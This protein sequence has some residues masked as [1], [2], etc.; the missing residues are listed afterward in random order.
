[1]KPYGY[2]REPLYFVCPP[3]NFFNE[4]YV[5]HEVRG[6]ETVALSPSINLTVERKHSRDIQQDDI[7]QIKSVLFITYFI[8]YSAVHARLSHYD[9]QIPNS[10]HWS[11]FSWQF[12]SKRADAL[13]PK[14]WWI[15]TSEHECARRSF[16]PNLIFQKS[17]LS[18]RFSITFLFSRVTRCT[19]IFEILS[20][21][22]R[23]FSDSTKLTRRLYYTFHEYHHW[24]YMI[25]FLSD[26][27]L[28]YWFSRGSSNIPCRSKELRACSQ[29]I[30]A[31]TV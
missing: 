19:S 17:I 27:L 18:A 11:H 1:M 8:L 28:N 4:I 22:S 20:L 13:A 6:E 29:R 23:N 15:A 30:K 26:I 12:L 9:R 7:S 2:F 24:N 25:I 14:H 5:I 31:P 3:L 21:V 10:F 16:F